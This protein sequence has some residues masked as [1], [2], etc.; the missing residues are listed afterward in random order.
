M[1]PRAVDLD[2]LP[3]ASA[4]LRSRSLLLGWT[5]RTCATGGLACALE[6]GC[7]SRITARIAAS[8]SRLTTTAGM[9]GGVVLLGAIGVAPQNRTA[10]SAEPHGRFGWRWSAEGSRGVDGIAAPNGASPE[11][12]VQVE[13]GA[14][15]VIGAARLIFKTGL[16]LSLALLLISYLDQR[17]T[18][19][20]I[21]GTLAVIFFLLLLCLPKSAGRATVFSSNTRQQA[22]ISLRF[23]NATRSWTVKSTSLSLIERLK[24]AAPEASDWGR[25]QGIYLPMIEGWLRRVPG[26]GEESADLAQEVLIIVF[27]EVPR[28]DR[29]R[30]GSFRAWLA[31]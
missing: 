12:E 5:G 23:Q 3:T 25:L 4:A 28:F 7:S 15:P 10:T 8:L 29:Q 14:S 2:R 30:V 27:R 20:V 22:R 1:V 6:I 24:A 9:A 18:A 17:S 31:R 21:F 13:T 26:L 19:T 16:V 11:L